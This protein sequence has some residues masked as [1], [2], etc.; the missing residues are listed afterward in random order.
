MI[1][2]DDIDTVEVVAVTL[3]TLIILVLTLYGGR[4]VNYASNE[5][6]FCYELL[7]FK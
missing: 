2:I 1:I 4:G 6:R 7:Y 5:Y 3:S